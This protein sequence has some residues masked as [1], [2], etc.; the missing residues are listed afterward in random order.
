MGRTLFTAMHLATF[1]NDAQNRCLRWYKQR[2]WDRQWSKLDFRPYWLGDTPRPFVIS[3]FEKGWLASGMTVLEIGCGLGTS[4]AWLAER[5]VQV[6][7]V[8]VSRH[9]IQRARKTHPNQPGLEFQ[10]ADVC[11]P[12]KIL[13]D[14]NIIMDT[15]C[16]QHIP[17]SLRHG[18]CQNLRTW[19]RVGSRFVVTMH[20]KH[21]SANERLS[22]VQALFSADFDLIC[23][24]QVKPANPERAKFL[25]S[26]FHFVRRRDSTRQ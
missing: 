16:L 25:N 2:V 20:T 17:A 10:Q 3:S 11:A 7:A 12:T 23:T 4:A 19:T 5:G 6:V 22:E 26:V 9:V 8:D 21:R 18:Y 13:R 15:G 24:E 1:F 14:F